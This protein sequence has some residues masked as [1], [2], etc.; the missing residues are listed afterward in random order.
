M[1]IQNNLLKLQ[2]IYDL[3]DRWQ[4][5]FSFVCR[6]GCA[7]C[8][9]RAVLVTQLEVELLAD[10]FPE[11]V[12]ETR[13]RLS[14]QWAGRRWPAP[15]L[16][17]NGFAARCLAGEPEPPDTYAP[18]SGPCFFLDEEDTCRVYPA[19]PLACRLMASSKVCDQAAETPAIHTSMGSIFMQAVEHLDGRLWGNLWN[20]IA[21]VEKTTG[22][23]DGL[24]P[25]QPLPGILAT[26]EEWRTMRET[27]VE[28]FRI[29]GIAAG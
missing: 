13:Q 17:T 23:R 6:P 4:H 10:R 9:T 16:T 21:T 29:V 11:L 15:R 25:C 27:A 24:R 18:N 8:C 2:E 19:R 20:F 1:V 12:E 22:N 28:L 14:R 3:W 7:A 5:R 26:E